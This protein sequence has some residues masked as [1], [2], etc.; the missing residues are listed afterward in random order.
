M[1]H[2]QFGLLTTRKVSAHESNMAQSF[3]A[4]KLERYFQ[5]FELSSSDAVNVMKSLIDPTKLYLLDG[6]YFVNKNGSRIRKEY[7][8]QSKH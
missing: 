5:D 8:K 7:G 6:D 2:E 3:I 1:N 4:G